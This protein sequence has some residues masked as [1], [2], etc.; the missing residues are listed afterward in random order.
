MQQTST[1]SNEDYGHIIGNRLA[2]GYRVRHIGGRE[3]IVPEFLE[4]S[5]EQ[6]SAAIEHA[7]NNN[8]K[9]NEVC[10]VSFHEQY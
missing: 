5:A 8:R 3:F 6:A 4:L 1:D 2:G 10:D 9:I 7:E